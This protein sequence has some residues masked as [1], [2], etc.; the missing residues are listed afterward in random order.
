MKK[1]LVVAL[2]FVLGPNLSLAQDYN[3]GLEAYQ[4]GF[5]ATALNEWIPLAEQGNERLQAKIGWMY[6]EGKGVG[7]NITEALK[8]YRLAAVQG[9][10]SAQYN[11][12]VM[13]EKGNGVLKD[14]AEALKWYRLA[15]EQGFAS[16]QVN[17]LVMYEYGAGVVQDNV[18]AHMWYNIASANGDENAGGY[19]DERAGLMTSNAIEKAQAMARECMAS[20]YKKCGT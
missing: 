19:R 2:F 7:K 13:Y 6:N 12:G 18:I 14:Y 11:L 5:Y 8:W 17:L 20:D 16:A 10:A 1:L 15:A 9:N 3:K 4:A